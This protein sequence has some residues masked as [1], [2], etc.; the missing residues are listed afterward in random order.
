M[1]IRKRFLVLAGGVSL[2]VLAGQAAVQIGARLQVETVAAGIEADGAKVSYGDVSVDVLTGRI[3]LAGLRIE[4]PSGANIA[5][6]RLALDGGWSLVTPALAAGD[7][8]LDDVTV[9]FGN[10]TYQIKSLT[11]SGTSSTR[12]EIAALFDKAGTTPLSAR[13]R[14][15]SATS[16]TSPEMVMRQKQGDVTSSVLYRDVRL[17]NVRDGVAAT[18]STSS[19]AF[20]SQ[21]GE[22]NVAATFGKVS[23]SAIDMVQ[24][25]RVYGE[26]AGEAPEELRTVYADFA[27]DN[28]TG[29]AGKGTTFGIARIAGKDVKAR[30]SKQ[31]WT[32]M[33]K[34]WAGKRDIDKM[35]PEERA[36]FVNAIADMFD[37]FSIGLMEGTEITGEDTSDAKAPKVKVAR[38]AFEGT[39]GGKP[40]AFRVEGFDVQAKDGHVRIGE[41][42]HTGWSYAPTLKAL[43]ETLGDPS[44]NMSDLQNS[45]RRFVPKLGTLSFRGLD[46]DVPDESAKEANPSA[47]NIRFGVKRFEIATGDEYEGV[48]TALNLKL[49]NLA[50]SI[51]PDSKEEGLKDL[52]A[53]GYSAIDLS[54]VLDGRWNKDTSDFVISNLGAQ[55]ASMGSVNVKGTFGN[56]TSDVFSGDQAAAQVALLG[57]TVKGVSVA[58]ENKGLF[59]KLV[60]REARKQGKSAGQMRKELGAAAQIGIPMFLG[61]GAQAKQV[62]AAVAKFLLK[63]NRLT[64]EAKAK[65]AEGLGVADFMAAQNDPQALLE[66]V[67]LTAKAE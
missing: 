2:A 62:A 3:A 12:E 45:A 41:I 38:I 29:R 37:S 35:P 15:L 60:E 19:G 53:M 58:I 40:A 52:L 21:G 39:G 54:A 56:V 33:V 23:A 59:E 30:P 43:R 1:T 13:L 67:D 49:D 25:A 18:F 26:A 66:A 46:L 16:I 11:V 47:P 42:A 8:T 50:L 5:V 24:I 57:A 20:A 22:D 55:G 36:R 51:P 9:E 31:P 14:K 65:S 48:P 63:P 27:V 44:V 64:V 17:D 61:G 4:D 34:E 7:V 32:A 6:G 10:Q 28:I